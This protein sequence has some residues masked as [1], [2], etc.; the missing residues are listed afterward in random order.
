[1]W[2]KKDNTIVR[3]FDFPDF[4]SG[5]AFVNKVGDLAEAI[6]MLPLSVFKPAGID[7]ADVAAFRKL[8]EVVATTALK[9]G[10]DVGRC[11]MPGD[12]VHWQ[13]APHSG[14]RY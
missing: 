12:F 6:D 14:P 2:Q 3:E 1:M 5:L 11:A 13:L 4:K 10:I 8:E 9:L 7:W